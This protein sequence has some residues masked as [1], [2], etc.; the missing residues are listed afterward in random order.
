MMTSKVKHV[1]LREV[2]ANNYEAVIDLKCGTDQNQ[3]TNS[4]G[5]ALLQ[6]AYSEMK[7]KV[8]HYA[9]CAGD[10]VAGMLRLDFTLLPE[11]YGLADMLIDREHQRQGYAGE[12]VRCALEIFRQ[13]GRHR[14]VSL[15]VSPDNAA[16]IA[17]CAKT[18]F[19]P[20][21]ETVSDGAL[22]VYERKL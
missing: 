13:E 8:R 15:L 6:S 7:G 9:V 18:G 22:L 20:T 2:D 16:S 10:T 17:L 12:A 14:K 19:A 11:S 5:W 3:F 21:G 1:E 4:P